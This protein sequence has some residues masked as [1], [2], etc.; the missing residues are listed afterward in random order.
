MQNRSFEPHN[1]SLLVSG[2]LI[3]LISSFFMNG[4]AGKKIDKIDKNTTPNRLVMNTVIS[5]ATSGLTQMIINQYGN[6]FRKDLSETGLVQQN[7]IRNLC[8]S[9]ISGMVA[10]TACCDNVD[11]WAA[12][13]IGLIGCLIYEQTKKLLFRFEI[14]DPLDISQTHGICGFW[15]LVAAGI[16]DIDRGYLMTGNGSYLGV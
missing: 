3:I 14:D 15:A 9:I 2:T 13:V 7:N 10:I 16:F 12:C 8:N 6:A 1:I 4:G 11:L 5:S